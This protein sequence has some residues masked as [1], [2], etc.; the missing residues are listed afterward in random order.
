MRI[1][2]YLVL[3]LIAVLALGASATADT[4]DISVVNPSPTHHAAKSAGH[5]AKGH[6]AKGKHAKAKHKGKHKG[7]AKHGKHAKSKSGHRAP[8]KN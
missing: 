7:K 6:H 5:H 3:P 4:G 2:R 1:N 8:A